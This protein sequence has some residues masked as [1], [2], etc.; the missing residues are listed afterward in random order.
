MG[1]VTR[2][3]IE[4]DGFTYQVSVEDESGCVAA[5]SKEAPVAAP[6]Q[7]APEAPKA[8]RPQ[9]RDRLAVN[10]M[11]PGRVC[12]ILV[13]VGDEV[14]EGDT[15]LMLEA[16]KMESPIYATKSG[17]IDSIEVKTGDNVAAGQVLLNIL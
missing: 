3:K 1:K 4:V 7:S 13:Q 17:V 12:S 15:L 9:T 6:R 5:V 8:A 2:Y 10:T 16:M 11:M 14:N